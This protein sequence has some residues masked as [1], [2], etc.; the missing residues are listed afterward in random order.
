[1][2]LFY[3][4]G[5]E[6][7]SITDTADTIGV[8]QGLYYWY[9]SLKEAPFNTTI[10]QYIEELAGKFILPQ[11]NKPLTSKEILEM[12]PMMVETKDINYYKAFHVNED[13]RFHNQLALKVCEKLWKPAVG[14]LKYAQ[15]TEE[16]H[17]DDI[18]TVARLYIYSQLGVPL[19]GNIS[20]EEKGERVHAFLLRALRL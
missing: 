20:K 3:E 10:D 6:R 16:I 17:L 13:R 8:V 19:D 4:K 18:E 15:G 5:Y 9:F 14:L 12:I 7:T 1:M 2:R 11:S